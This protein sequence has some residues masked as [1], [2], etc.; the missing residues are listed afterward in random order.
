[1]LG[2]PDK[3]ADRVRQVLDEMYT[4]GRDGLS[5]NEDAGQMSAWYI[6]SAMG[7]YPVE[8]AGARYWFGSPLFDEVEV[9]VP[10]GVFTIRAENNSAR[11]RYIK[12]VTLDGKEYTL[13]YIAHSDLKAGSVLTFTMGE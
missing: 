5:G 8:P 9:E 1:M 2:A 7:F 6:M 13:P 3:A 10:G 4:T 11:N 12:K